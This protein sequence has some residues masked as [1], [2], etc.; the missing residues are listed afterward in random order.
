M[1]FKTLVSRHSRP[2]LNTALRI[3]GNSQYAQDIHQEGQEQYEA[4]FEGPLQL[5]DDE[6]RDQDVSGH[7]V[8]DAGPFHIAH[9]NEEPQVGLRGLGEHELAQLLH[10]LLHGLLRLDGFSQVGLDGVGVDPLERRGHDQERQEQRQPHDD[11]FGRDVLRCQGAPDEGQH[12]DD[13][14]ERRAQHQQGGN[15]AQEGQQQQYLDG[16][17]QR[18]RRFRLHAIK[19]GADVTERGHHLLLLLLLGQSRAAHAGKQ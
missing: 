10:P 13:P 18:V 1:P 19:Q 6:R 14:R 9:L 12:D 11:R 2:V 15:D 17:G 7:V 5:A 3:V 16:P 4:Q 8:A